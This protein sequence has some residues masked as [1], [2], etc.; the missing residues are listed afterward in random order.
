M[1]E[2]ATI[3][4]G[5]QSKKPDSLDQE[6][7]EHQKNILTKITDLYSEATNLLPNSSILYM[8]WS[9]FCLYHCNNKQRSLV[10]LAECMKRSPLIDEEFVAFRQ[11]KI[12]N[13]ESSS[14]NVDMLEFIICE[15]HVKNA[16]KHERKAVSLQIR[17]WQELAKSDPNLQE[18]FLLGSSVN[19][20][21]SLAGK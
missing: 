8:F 3:A 16:N 9:N 1:M 10:V 11:R 18:L 12:M 4:L 6:K 2:E 17:F 21:V 20:E 13:E 7:I 5:I 19:A 15:S 14:E